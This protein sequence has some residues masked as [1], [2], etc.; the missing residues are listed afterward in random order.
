MK[1]ANLLTNK[2]MNPTQQFPSWKDDTWLDENFSS[3]YRTSNVP[4]HVQKNLLLV[5]ILNHMNPNHTFP[6]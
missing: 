2:Q 6:A 1:L 4:L 5:P 3:F